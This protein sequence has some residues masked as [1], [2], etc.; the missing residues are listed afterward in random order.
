M[1]TRVWLITPW[2]EI[3][4][5][6]NNF[7][8]ELSATDN[9][10][11]D[12]NKINYM[13]MTNQ[14]TTPRMQ[15]RPSQNPTA[16]TIQKLNDLKFLFDVQNNKK[17]TLRHSLPLSCSPPI[18]KIFFVFLR[19]SSTSNSN[20][21][22]F[23]NFSNSSLCRKSTLQIKAV[24]INGHHHHKHEPW[25]IRGQIYQVVEGKQWQAEHQQCE[26]DWEN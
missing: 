10:L 4:N 15:K 25:N 6:L 9:L 7:D 12:F 16:S 20:S 23:T 21:D 19:S 1:T 11:I 2:S 26:K 5:A 24:A 8:S 18:F 14:N 17:S 3:F 13:K 22:S